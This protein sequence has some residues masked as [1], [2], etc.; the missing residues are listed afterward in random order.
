[1]LLR[2]K[3]PS[4]RWKDAYSL[5]IQWSQAD[6]FQWLAKIDEI[7]NRL[8]ALVSSSALAGPVTKKDLETWDVEVFTCIKRLSVSLEPFA[9]REFDKIGRYQSGLCLTTLNN[10]TVCAP[11]LK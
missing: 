11:Y 2:R 10:L 8:G 3:G 1:M 4:S 9:S 7:R 5:F 6:D